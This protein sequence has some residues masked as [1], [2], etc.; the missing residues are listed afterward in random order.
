M[1]PDRGRRAPRRRWHTGAPGDERAARSGPPGPRGQPGRA[2]VSSARTA[3][4]PLGSGAVPRVG[5][6]LGP[7]TRLARQDAIGTPRR[8]FVVGSLTARTGPPGTAW[9]VVLA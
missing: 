8:D 4:E 9:S 5:R 1:R 6:S 2:R 3:G 7:W